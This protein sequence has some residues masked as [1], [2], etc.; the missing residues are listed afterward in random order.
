MFSYCVFLADTQLEIV[1]LGFPLD[2]ESEKEEKNNEKEVDDKLQM[3]A[4]ALA[5]S[6]SNDFLNT[7]STADCQSLHHPEVA[8]PPPRFSLTF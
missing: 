8:T 7:Y 2:S 4:H 6:S 1:E 5:F 3:Y